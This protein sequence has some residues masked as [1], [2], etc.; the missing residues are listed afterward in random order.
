MGV[1][2]QIVRGRVRV[3][4]R[5]GAD[6]WRERPQVCKSAMWRSVRQPRSSSDSLAHIMLRSP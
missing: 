5:V 1:W 6:F 2:W 4:Q 3:I